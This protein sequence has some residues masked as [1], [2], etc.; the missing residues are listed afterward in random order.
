MLREEKKKIAKNGSNVTEM[1][2]Q[3]QFELCENERKHEHNPIFLS[4]FSTIG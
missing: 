4:D 2:N 3:W 1:P